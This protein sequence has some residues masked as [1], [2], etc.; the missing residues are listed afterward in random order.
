M[1]C[2]PHHAG[3]GRAS[4]T[5]RGAVARLRARNGTAWLLGMALLGSGCA[6]TPYRYGRFHPRG[7]DEAAPQPVTFRHGKP[8]RTLD[9]LGLLAGL[10]ERV[11]TLNSKASNH[12]VSPEALQTLPD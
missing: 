6:S 5:P 8:H 1:A 3:S 7:P 2:F 9:R 12:Q 4:L 10:A 11:F